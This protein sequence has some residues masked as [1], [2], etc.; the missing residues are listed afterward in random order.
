M[1]NDGFI[2]ASEIGEYVYCKRA[3]WLR[4]KGELK[5]TDLMKTGIKK[6]NE[7]F[8]SVEKSQVGRLLALGLLLVGLVI[9]VIYYLLQGFFTL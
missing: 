2:K 8:L 9:L 3:W 6:H 4:T 7:Q 1:K 5:Q